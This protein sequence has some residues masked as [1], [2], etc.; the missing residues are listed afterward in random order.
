MNIYIKLGL[1]GCLIG[2]V[3][4]LALGN[5][6]AAIWAGIAAAVFYINMVEPR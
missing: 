6:L 3:A 4:T 5:W 2:I 1:A